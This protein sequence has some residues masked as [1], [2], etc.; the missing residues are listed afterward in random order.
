MI[1]SMPAFAIVVPA[2]HYPFLPLPIVEGVLIERMVI[3]VP[4]DI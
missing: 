2:V 3:S 4:D 1:Q